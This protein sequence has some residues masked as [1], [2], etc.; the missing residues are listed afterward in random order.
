MGGAFFA[1]SIGVFNYLLLLVLKSSVLTVLAQTQVCSGASPTNSTQAVGNCY[2]ALVSVLLPLTVFLIF[3]AVIVF[4]FLFG[5]L[6]ESLPGKGYRTKA[7]IISC[8][9]V[10][11][12]L[13]FGLEGVSTDTT[14][15]LILIAFDIVAAAGFTH[16]LGTFY[17]R[18]T[19]IVEFST[20]ESDPLEIVVGRKIANGKTLTFSTRSSH[21]IVARTPESRVFKEWTI[22]G[23]VSV[24]D[25]R[26][27]ETVF[28]VEGD[29]LLRAK[30]APAT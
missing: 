28:H 27:Y 25:A 13:F 18:Y 15:R 4:A 22:S 14:Q 9:V 24:D 16:I 3:I 19:W 8:L 30:S 23:G 5:S 12:M 11:T 10:L 7:S 2:V 26:S 6:F 1:G 20:P 21:R 17:R 29:G